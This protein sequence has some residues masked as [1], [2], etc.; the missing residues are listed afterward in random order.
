GRDDSAACAQRGPRLRIP[1]PLVWLALGADRAQTTTSRDERQRRTQLIALR[2]G[3]AAVLI[4]VLVAISQSGGSDDS[5]SSGGGEISGIEQNGTVLGDS[6]VPVTV[7]EYGDLQ[8]PI[9]R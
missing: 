5:G 6:S 7:F 4:A 9:R 3:L 1:R 8:L 2:V